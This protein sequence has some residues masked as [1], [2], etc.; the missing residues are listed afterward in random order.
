MHGDELGMV[1]RLVEQ[2]GG[3]TRLRRDLSWVR[4]GYVEEIYAVAA[5][6]PE[7]ADPRWIQAERA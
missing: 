2:A 3:Y 1:P 5:A 6:E 7:S 4:A